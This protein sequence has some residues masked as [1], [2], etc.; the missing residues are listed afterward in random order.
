MLI[1]L[2]VDFIGVIGVDE[3]KKHSL[4]FLTIWKLKISLDKTN[5]NNGGMLDVLG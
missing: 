3:D 1:N 4:F 5:K 2:K